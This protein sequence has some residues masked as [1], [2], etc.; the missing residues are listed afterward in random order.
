MSRIHGVLF[1]KEFW[2]KQEAKSW[3]LKHQLFP[4]RPM[5]ISEKYWRFRIT[6]PNYNKFEYRS[7]RENN[8]VFIFEFEK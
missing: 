2:T 7:H 6:N 5:N 3:L 4:I 1:D 8:I